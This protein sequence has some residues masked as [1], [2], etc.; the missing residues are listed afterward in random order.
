MELLRSVGP[1]RGLAGQVA[2]LRK[3]LPLTAG[4]EA[5]ADM[6]AWG[7]DTPVTEVV[8][9]CLARLA[10]AH[11]AEHFYVAAHNE[12]G[13]CEPSLRR[14]AAV[15]ET[16]Y[17]TMVCCDFLPL[18]QRRFRA[19]LPPLLA[20]LRALSNRGV[21]DWGDGETLN[22]IEDSIGEG[23]DADDDY[24]RAT[25][26]DYTVGTPAQWLDRIHTAPP[27]PPGELAARAAGLLK[28]A[29]HPT[30][31]RICLWLIHTADMLGR[32]WHNHE[33]AS[34]SDYV[35]M[36]PTGSADEGHPV[37]HWDVTCL[38]WAR[39]DLYSQ[40]ERD[41]LDS[42][43]GEYGS[44]GAI[45]DLPVTEAPAAVPYWP[46]LLTALLTD[47]EVIADEMW[48]HEEAQREKKREKKL[49]EI[50]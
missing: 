14:L 50:L 37:E 29:R 3:L 12:E 39:S 24:F 6:P 40:W 32:E 47:L 36:A 41:R 28:R 34:A 43:W 18:V 49:I 19:L 25:H 9:W 7:A 11:P 15:P 2:F 1:I 45:V 38:L 20:A 8:G 44:F 22:M 21:K 33:L 35:Q 48:A 16:D 31:R 13:E 4:H 30:A 27:V 17:A 5:F 46:A 26:R 10:Q 23:E 42:D